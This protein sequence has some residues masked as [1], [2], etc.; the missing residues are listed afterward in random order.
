MTLFTFWI[1]SILIAWILTGIMLYQKSSVF[2][3]RN[4]LLCWLLASILP[5]FNLGIVLAALF[6]VVEKKLK[7]IEKWL[8]GPV[9]KTTDKDW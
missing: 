4:A 3:N 6:N 1:L 9:Y 5:I 2:Y 8:D 7:P